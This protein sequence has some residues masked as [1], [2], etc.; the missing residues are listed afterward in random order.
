MT[1]GAVIICMERGV[2]IGTLGEWISGLGAFLA[3]LVALI[4]PR[5]QAEWARRERFSSDL[6]LLE[7]AYYA[8]NRGVAWLGAISDSSGLDPELP[9]RVAKDL[10]DSGSLTGTDVA[11]DSISP[12]M[13]NDIKA[14]ASITMLKNS[15]YDQVASL[16][17][18]AMGN[19]DKNVENIINATR[20]KRSLASSLEVIEN[21]R[22]RIEA[23]E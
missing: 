15:W 7:A 5:K 8:V 13:A 1:A 20:L 19:N 9:R 14:R 6:A 23:G 17:L 18:Y 22:A 21:M 4:V 3:V 16:K 11:I 12:H 2:G 10:L